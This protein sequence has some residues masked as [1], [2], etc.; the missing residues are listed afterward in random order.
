MLL[1]VVVSVVTGGGLGV[2]W[3]SSMI[4]MSLSV[5]VCLLL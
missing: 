5:G 3:S 1:I 2:L 4:T